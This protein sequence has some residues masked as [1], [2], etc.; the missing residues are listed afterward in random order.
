MHVSP[1]PPLFC[2]QRPSE[3]PLQPSNEL[4]IDMHGAPDL[5]FT[6]RGKEAGGTTPFVNYVYGKACI[7]RLWTAKAICIK[8]IG[9]KDLSEKKNEKNMNLCWMKSKHSATIWET[10]IRPSWGAITDKK[11]VSQ[12]CKDVSLCQKDK[13]QKT[14]RL[15]R[16]SKYSVSLD[17]VVSVLIYLKNSKSG[18]C[19]IV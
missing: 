11:L 3:R 2:H 6:V 16:N 8:S 18:Y 19:F 13:T 12:A 1:P 4:R 14:I 5:R 17:M 10:I 7:K 15:A 9:L